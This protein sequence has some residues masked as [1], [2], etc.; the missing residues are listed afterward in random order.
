MVFAGHLLQY[1]LSGLLAAG[2]KLH[3]KLRSEALAGEK[4]GGQ[5]AF[6]LLFLPGSVFFFLPGWAP[7]ALLLASLLYYFALKKAKRR[8]MATGLPAYAPV[9]S[10][11]GVFSAF[12]LTAAVMG[13]IG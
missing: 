11:T 12:A 8:E 9:L 1:R 6:L 7:M 4:A 10:V 2:Q 5:I 3:G 13:W